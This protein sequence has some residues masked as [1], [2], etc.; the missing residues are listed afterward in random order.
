VDGVSSLRS[1]IPPDAKRKQSGIDLARSSLAAV[2]VPK[3]T[4]RLRA[5]E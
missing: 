4:R 2:A 5:T 1:D 3:T